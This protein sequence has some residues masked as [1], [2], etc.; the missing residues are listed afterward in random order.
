MAD[1]P[2]GY[3]KLDTKAA[4]ALA[5]RTQ[6][7][8][9]E[10][11]LGGWS[12]LTHFAAAN[13]YLK[14]FGIDPAAP[15]SLTA[16]G[17]SLSLRASGLL[18]PVGIVPSS[19]GDVI[20]AAPMWIVDQPK[21]TVI[22]FTDANGSAYTY[23]SSTNS[24][25]GLSD[26]GA[27]TSGSGNGMA[28]YDNYIYIAKNT[29]IARY[30]PLDGSPTF[31]GTYWTGTLSKSALTNT[32]YPIRFATTPN[33]PNHVMHRHSDGKLYIA[34]VVGNQGVLHY[35]AT[36]KGSVEGDTDN[37][38]TFSK[39]TF[40]YGLWP[41][42]IESYGS[43]LAVALIENTATSGARSTRAKMAFWD[44]TSQNFNSITWVE[45]PD[46]IITA[47]KNVDGVLY[48]VSSNYNTLG[49]RVS[50]YIGGS[51]VEEVAYIEDGVVPLAGGVDA[52]TRRLLFGSSTAGNVPIVYSYGLQKEALGQ[53]LHGIMRA[54]SATGTSPTG[55][56]ITA[57]ALT[58]SNLYSDYPITGHAGSG[59]NTLNI[60][61]VSFG[62]PVYSSLWWSKLYQIG[63]PFKITKIRIPLAQTMAVGM[64]VVPSIYIDDATATFTAFPNIDNTNFPGASDV[65]LRPNALTGRH[66][67]FISLVWNGTIK[68]VV[69][70]PIIIDYEFTDDN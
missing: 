30:G 47:L 21:S 65:V 40:G 66:N 35:I 25:L 11:I 14:G 67:F 1:D 3:P 23:T 63:R 26:A 37:G 27:L 39:L 38:S 45:F 56:A 48:I 18:A 15:V 36:T 16:L 19:N 34:D 32:S 69:G 54:V 49:F 9:I 2:Q 12:P 46:S 10:S 50:R 52:S 28:Y 59:G 31:N 43:S 22:Y 70:L 41:T 58:N 61:Y 5:P 20:A 33:L 17:T 4:R 68:C 53:G 8:V 13:Q 55:V 7:L 62:T 42:A 44:T 60:A 29:D 64:S 24:T 6:Q 57:L 51:T